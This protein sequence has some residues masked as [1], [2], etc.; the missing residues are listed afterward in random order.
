[1]QRTHCVGVGV[2]D[3]RASDHLAQTDRLDIVAVWVDQESSVVLRT[4]VG[5]R[6][7]G[8]VVLP[9]RGQTGSVEA[10]DRSAA[11]RAKRDGRAARCLCML[12]QPQR[13]LARGSKTRTGRIA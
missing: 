7:R 8:S 1:G 9:A 6:P 10:V 2:R 3:G 5:T 13:W 4:V 12:R 11:F